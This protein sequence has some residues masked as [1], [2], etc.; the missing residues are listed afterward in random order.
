MKLSSILVTLSVAG[1]LAACG[2][3]TSG[4]IKQDN[5]NTTPPVATSGSAQG[6][7]GGKTTEGRAIQGVVLSDGGYVFLY[8][9]INAPTTLAGVVQGTGIS[10]KTVAGYFSSSNTV[11]FSLEKSTRFTGTVA[12]TYASKGAFTG[13][14]ST[15]AGSIGFDL[16]YDS[17]YSDG[18]T[19]KSLAGTWAATAVDTSQTLT[20]AESGA[21]TGLVNGCAQTG[22]IKPRTDANVF[23]V[24]LTFGAAPCTFAGQSVAGVMFKNK[25]GALYGALTDSG[26]QYVVPYFGWI[27][28]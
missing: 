9:G 20:I 6:F 2:G 15:L 24:T 21:L 1:L 5:G 27:K 26:R 12:A 18:A 23:D 22:T 13:I 17:T 16:P 11:Q 19:L 8:S 28:Q 25:T 4:E 14:V 7:W 3:G 10:D